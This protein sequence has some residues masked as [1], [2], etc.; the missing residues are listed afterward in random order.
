MDQSSIS[1]GS[2]PPLLLAKKSPSFF[3]PIKAVPSIK[4]IDKL[5]LKNTN[6]LLKEE[7]RNYQPKV[8]E[9]F[10][11]DWLNYPVDKKFQVVYNSFNIWFVWMR[12]TSRGMASLDPQDSTIRARICN[13]QAILGNAAGLFLIMSVSGF[14]T[15]I[16][17]CNVFQRS[18]R[19]SFCSCSRLF[20]RTFI[21]SR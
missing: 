4:N 10:L 15:K 6:H 12:W 7:E 17:E 19:F 21:Q 13:Q 3:G 20:L 5:Q 14:L 1:S 18:P 9:N 2:K 16:S 8:S 11:E